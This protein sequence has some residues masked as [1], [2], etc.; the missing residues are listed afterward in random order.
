MAMNPHLKIAFVVAPLLAIA[1]WGLAEMYWAS[2]HPEAA[3]RIA[4]RRA[5][6]M[7]EK[8]C[9]LKA[10]DLQLFIRGEFDATGRLNALRIE[11]TEPLDGIVAGVSPLKG[12]RDRPAV[13]TSA[14]GR[15]WR[16][17]LPDAPPPSKE[18]ARRL[19][20]VAVAG[21][22]TYIGETRVRY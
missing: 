12:E 17:R 18:E 16:A 7:R 9:R 1:G 15:V 13:F 22:K 3:A 4:P 5:C 10:G 2:T 19:R 21:G 20:V 6:D 14:D 11:S 8:A